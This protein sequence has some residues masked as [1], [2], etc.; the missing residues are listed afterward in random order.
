[1]PD[2]APFGVIETSRAAA[3][4]RIT[5]GSSGSTQTGLCTS[6]NPSSQR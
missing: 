6:A 2:E 1:M 4:N 5:P 3:G